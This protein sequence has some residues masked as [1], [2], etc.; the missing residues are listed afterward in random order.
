MMWF[1]GASY[2]HGYIDD[3]LEGPFNTLKEAIVE[4]DS[5]ADSWRT[6][7]PSVERD[8]PENGGQSADIFFYDPRVEGSGEPYPDRRL[9]YGP[10]G[11]L[12]VL[13]A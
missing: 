6:Y 9:E 1:G 2:A 10:R 4:F 3:D 5:R 11:G 8:T 12:H 13:P 7:Y